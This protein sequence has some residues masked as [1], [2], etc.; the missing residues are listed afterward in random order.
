VHGPNKKKMKLK[1]K[2]PG[3]KHSLT[4]H[5]SGY[6]T[7]EGKQEQDTSLPKDRVTKLHGRWGILD[8]F[9]TNPTSNQL[10]L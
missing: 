2:P 1:I 8:N 9:S 10:T 3:A 4:S 5:L 6:I 7:S